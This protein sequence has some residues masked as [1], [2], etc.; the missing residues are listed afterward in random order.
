[1]RPAA[2]H[3][4][5]QSAASSHNWFEPRVDCPRSQ[6]T[7]NRAHNPPIPSMEDEPCVQELSVVVLEGSE[8]QAVTE[9]QHMARGSHCFVAR[10]DGQATAQGH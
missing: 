5:L 4:M 8:P 3:P 1:M 7:D 6:C 2:A 10:Q 9:L